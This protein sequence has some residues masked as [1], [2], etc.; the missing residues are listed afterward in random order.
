MNIATVLKIVRAIDEGPP[1]SMVALAAEVGITRMSL[2]RNVQWARDDLGLVI[3]RDAHGHPKIDD[4]GVFSKA[5]LRERH[6]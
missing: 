6:A 2:W 1:P 4:W 5:R 3:V